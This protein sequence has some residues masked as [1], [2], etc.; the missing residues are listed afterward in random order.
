MAR[1][2]L[3]YLRD[4]VDKARGQ[5]FRHRVLA[6]SHVDRRQLCPRRLAHRLIAAGEVRRAQPAEPLLGAFG[7]AVVEERAT[8]RVAVEEG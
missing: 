2:E 7:P 4:T 3:D 1:R 8:S 6:T 5:D